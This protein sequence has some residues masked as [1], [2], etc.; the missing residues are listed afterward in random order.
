[1]DLLANIEVNIDFPEYDEDEITISIAK[2]EM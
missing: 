2:A 1:M